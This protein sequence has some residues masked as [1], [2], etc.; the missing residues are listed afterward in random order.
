MVQWVKD[1]VLLL[2]YLGLLTWELPHAVG[3]AKIEEKKLCICTLFLSELLFFTSYFTPDWFGIL[4]LLIVDT[5]DF[6]TIV[7]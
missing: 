4:Q 6:T 2:Q 3:M 5:D 1:P 7:F